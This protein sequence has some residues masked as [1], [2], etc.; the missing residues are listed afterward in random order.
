[1]ASYIV[2]YLRLLGWTLLPIAAGVVLRRCGLGRRASRYLF[3]FA[4]F[5]C[6][7]PIVLLATW[8]AKITGGSQCLPFL[9]LA[10]CDGKGCLRLGGDPGLDVG[11][12][13]GSRGRD[14]RDLIRPSR[15][16]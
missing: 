1:M 13:A 6:Q 5:C 2:P 12:R 15:L 3:V 16:V 9:A 14:S 4:L 10:G 8:A 7:T 11:G